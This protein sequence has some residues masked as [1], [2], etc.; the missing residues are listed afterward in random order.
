MLLS[1]KITNQTIERTDS[2][3]PVA[4][5]QNYL[6]A[7]FDLPSDWEGAV[8]AV[9][10]YENESPY[11]QLLD[12]EHKCMVPW[13][14][15]KTPGFRVSCFC[16]NLITANTVL[17]PVNESGYKRN[18]TPAPPTPDVYA[19]LIELVEEAVETADSVRE[20]AD[21]GVFDGEPGTTDYT[22]LINQPRTLYTPTEDRVSY[23]AFSTGVYDV[24]ESF[25]LIGVDSGIFVAKGAILSIK[26][27]NYGCSGVIV[28]NNDR[29]ITVFKKSISGKTFVLADLLDYNLSDFVD[30]TALAQTTGNST[31]AVMSQAAV[32]TALQNCGMTAQQVQAMIDASID[33][34]INDALA[35][36]IGQEEEN[37]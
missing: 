14:V 19:Q 4:N 26:V 2:E 34:E 21:N 15:I 7:E 24:G 22:E 16:G 36:I 8:T 13:E 23:T 35:D 33:E 28:G 5:S 12:G 3:K 30:K 11:L 37:E 25:T 1:F 18:Q 27:T 10:N 9:F 17:V 32:T 6:S 20:D 31:Q 29:G